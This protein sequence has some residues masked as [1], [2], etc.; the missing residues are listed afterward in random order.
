[1]CPLWGTKWVFISHKTTFFIVTAA[2]ASNFTQH[3]LARLCSGDVMC[4][5]WGTNWVFISQKTAFFDV[6]Q[7]S[8]ATQ[9]QYLFNVTNRQG[10]LLKAIGLKQWDYHVAVICTW[11]IL[12]V[13]TVYRPCSPAIRLSAHAFALSLVTYLDRVQMAVCVFMFLLFLLWSS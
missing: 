12:C 2:K 4:L 6:T 11:T 1:M 9:K 5:P 13:G 3:K 7:R 8:I 10:I